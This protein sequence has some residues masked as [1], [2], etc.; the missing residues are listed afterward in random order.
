M[1]RWPARRWRPSAPPAGLA[2]ED[3]LLDLARD[4]TRGRDLR[5]EALD[6]VAPRLPQ[7]RAAP[8][9]VPRLPARPRRA[10]APPARGRARPGPCP[11][12]RR[13]APG[14][15]AGRRR[16]R[17]RSCLPA[18]PAGV[19]AV[20]RPARRG[21]AGGGPRPVARPASLDAR[22]LAADPAQLPRRGP[23]TGRAAPPAARDPGGGEGVAPGRGRADPGPTATPCAGREVFFGN[24]AACST[25]HTI[26]SEGGHVGPDLS[27]IG[28]ARNGRDLLEAILFPSASF[29]RGYEPYVIATDDGRVHTGIIVRET[30][31][32]IVLV[33]PDR[34]EL[35]IPRRSIEA[36]EPS[37]VSVMPRG[38]EANLEPAGAGRPRRLPPIA[39]V[40]RS[41]LEGR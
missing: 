32:A 33:T 15:D 9:R 2:F 17:A 31:D 7:P 39:E 5:V 3:S 30:G 27:R 13:P 16:R 26:R 24:R 23:A 37:R 28:A 29:A 8:V 1:S 40:T 19:R 35:S 20:Q 4:R 14:P 22:G 11:A 12:R 38:L 21:V 6:A 10:A 41:V 25:C 36:I 34:L 18:A